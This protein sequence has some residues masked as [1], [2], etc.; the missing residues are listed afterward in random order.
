MIYF[1][2]K[3]KAPDAIETTEAFCD[4]L[5]RNDKNTLKAITNLETIPANVIKAMVPF[6]DNH[7]KPGKKYD[8]VNIAERDSN[9]AS[10]FRL[11]L[12]TK[13][14]KLIKFELVKSINRW[15]IRSVGIEDE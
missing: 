14:D 4:A 6:K 15:V 8:F 11:D 2:A 10:Y 13:D 5:I 7:L 1:L 12:L 9:D 3:S